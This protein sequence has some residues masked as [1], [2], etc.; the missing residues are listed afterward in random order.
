MREYKTV[1]NNAN[2][3][4]IIEK[5]RFI[6]YSFHISSQDEAENF[7]KSIKNNIMMLHTTVMLIY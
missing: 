6:G 5:S 4:I 2:D 7:I 1:L 3:E